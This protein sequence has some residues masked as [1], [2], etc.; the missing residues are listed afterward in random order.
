M[1]LFRLQFFQQYNKKKEMTKQLD[2]L[3]YLSHSSC[4]LKL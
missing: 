3:Q 1:L 2:N 4:G